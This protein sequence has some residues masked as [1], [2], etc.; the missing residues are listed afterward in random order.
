M[1]LPT[2]GL[3]RRNQASGLVVTPSCDLSNRKVNSIS[4]LPILSFTDWVSSGEFIREAVGEMRNLASQFVGTGVSEVSVGGYYKIGDLFA[5]HG[6]SI[7]GGANPA[8]KAVDFWCRDIV[9]GHI[10]TLQQYTKSSPAHKSQ[11]W[12]G[13]ALPC[14]AKRTPDTA[15]DGETPDSNDLTSLRYCPRE[16]QPLSRGHP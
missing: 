15:A 3:L 12:T 10:H 14:L 6:D 16:P 2:H 13:T 1:N 7:G 11:R 4:Y 8:K 5:M 9:M